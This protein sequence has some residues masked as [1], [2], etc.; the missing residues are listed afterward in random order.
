MPSLKVLK[1]ITVLLGVLIVLGTT[2]VAV[3]IVRRMSE[4]AAVPSQI[5]VTLEEPAGTRI[6][7]IAATQDRLAVHL[8]GGGPDRVV[9]LD[10]HTG[11]RTGSIVLAH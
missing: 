4:P 6:A 8:Q 1:F 10:P 7:A 2:V 5:A 11:A 3:T 9:L